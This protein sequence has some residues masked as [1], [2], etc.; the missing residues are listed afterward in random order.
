MTYTRSIMGALVFLLAASSGAL[1]DTEE[2]ILAILKKADAA[3]RAVKSVSYHGEYFGFGMYEPRLPHI[4]GE[5]KVKE[6]RQSI[7]G[8]LLGKHDKTGH[9]RLWAEGTF[10]APGQDDADGV[11]FTISTDGSKVYRINR[12]S[13]SFLSTKLSVGSRVIDVAQRLYMLEFL[14]PTP[15]NDEINALEK[16]YEGKKTIGDVE[17]HVIH[18]KYLNNSLSRWFFGVDDYLPRRVDRILGQTEDGEFGYTLQIRD[19]VVSPK[20]DNAIFTMEVPEGY[21]IEEFVEPSTDKASSMLLSAGT[22]APDWTLSNPQGQEV[23]LKDLRGKVVVMD[24]WATWCAPC[25]QSMPQIQKL[26]EEFADEP[27]RFIGVN[28]WENGDPAAYMKDNNY[29]YELL[30]KADKIAES[31]R[32]VSI[33]T[34]Y[35]IDQKGRIAYASLGYTPDKDKK[36]ADVIRKCLSKAD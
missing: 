9:P 26:H 22:P 29:T 13:R 11:G 2:E 35:V 19:L 18:V 8:A 34:F 27:V 1:A 32:V 30:L 25:K 15:F 12:E 3:T 33:P 10:V 24:F 5:L 21:E 6:G 17:C 31:Y 14:H 28:L 20:L 7:L 36:I 4:S 23:S 16:K